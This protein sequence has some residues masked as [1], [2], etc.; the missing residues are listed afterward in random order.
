MDYTPE[1]IAQ[2]QNDIAVSQ[3]YLIDKKLQ[4]ISRNVGILTFAAVIALIFKHK[5]KIKD[6]KNVKGE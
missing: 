5:D 6:L 2:R 3:L 4:K 1:G